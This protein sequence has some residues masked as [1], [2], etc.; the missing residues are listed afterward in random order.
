MRVGD[1][2]T[3]DPEAQAADLDWLTT[4]HPGDLLSL[5]TIYERA[6]SLPVEMA[7]P[8]GNKSADF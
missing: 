2:K 5:S 6:L 7:G 8:K 3:E 1:F 4:Q